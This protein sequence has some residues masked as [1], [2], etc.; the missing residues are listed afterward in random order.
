MDNWKFD[1]KKTIE[2]Y[3]KL[4]SFYQDNGLNANNFNCKYNDKCS[5]SQ[6]REHM[7]FQFKGGT[8]AVMPFYDVYYKGR[9]IRVLIIGKENGYMRNK[10]YGTSDDFF[11]HT[12]N[13]LNCINW[14]E[15]NNHIKGTLYTLNKIFNVNSEYIYSS[16][17]LTNLL[18]CAYQNVNKFDN[19]SGVHDNITMRM[20]CKE[21]LVNEINIL[22]PTLIIVQGSW[23]IHEKIGIIPIL[24]DKYG[25]PK[26]IL[27]D[28]RYSNYGLFKY[29]DFM[30]I[31]SHHP[32]I[33]GH[34]MKNLAP[35]TLWPFVEYLKEIDYLPIIEKKDALR[36][37]ELVKSDIDQILMGINR[38]NNNLRKK[39]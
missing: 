6:N 20:N 11:D 27:Y 23:G 17:A 24:R 22:E 30:C 39:E 31:I 38:D 21:Y 29:K 36:Y 10:K 26:K 5:Q 16:Y 8:A 3:K 1:V 37:E 28:E 12:I 9:P 4:S 14:K 2:R 7:E 25:H 19:R 15:K 13:V 34:W 32:A 35:I 18:R 33:L